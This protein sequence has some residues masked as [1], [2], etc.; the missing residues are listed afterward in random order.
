M[1][2]VHSFEM[3]DIEHQDGGSNPVLMH[4]LDQFVEMTI[5]IC[6]IVEAGQRVGQ[7]ELNAALIARLQAILQPLAEDLGHRP[8]LQLVSIHRAGHII[9]RAQVE[10][11]GK[12]RQIPVFGDQ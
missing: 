1:G 6:P 3:V 8:R 12:A 5:Q 10:S 2:V 11:F 7:C 9:V 4:P